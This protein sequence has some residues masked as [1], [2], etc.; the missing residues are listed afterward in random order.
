MSGPSRLVRRYPALFGWGVATL[1]ILAAVA[2]APVLAPHDP[3]RLNMAQA[4]KAPSAAY[5]FGTDEAGRDIL[6]RVLYGG[7]ESIVAAFAVLI[8]AVVVGLTVGAASGWIVGRI[9]DVL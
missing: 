6:S 7:R 3:N 9:D 8:V 5:P 4:L 2:A 1:L